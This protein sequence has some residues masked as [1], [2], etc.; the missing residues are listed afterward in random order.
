MNLLTLLTVPVL[1]TSKSAPNVVSSHPNTDQNPRRIELCIQRYRQKRNLDEVRA[2]VYTKYLSLGGID[3]GA[4]V[5]T[6]S[7][8]KADYEEADASQIAAYNAT[9]KISAVQNSKYYNP[10]DEKDW[11]VD[12]TGIVKGFLYVC[13][14]SY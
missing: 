8:S 11:V 4:K 12:F 10:V 7:L 13:F 1:L 2:L 5:G 3:T 14:Q 9:D 6:R